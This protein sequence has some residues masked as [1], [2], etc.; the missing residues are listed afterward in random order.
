MEKIKEK[1]GIRHAVIWILVY[2]LLVNLGAMLSEGIGAEDA[3]TG[4]LLLLFSIYFWRYLQANNWLDYYG[5]RKTASADLMNSLYYAPL[6]LLVLFQFSN[7]IN[8]AIVP[9]KLLLIVLMMSGV[10]FLEELIFRGFLL[11]A[12]EEKSGRTRA[13]VIS[14]ITFGLGHIINL[15]RGYSYEEQVIQIL[16][17]AG[18]GIVLALLAFITQNIVPG[19]LFHILF[20]ISGSI[21]IEAAGSQA[22]YGL[23]LISILC[24][25]YSL[26]LFRM[27]KNP[28]RTYKNHHSLVSNGGR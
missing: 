12:I 8:S 19:I 1:N 6:V 2:L 25:A 13:V 7:G 22:F 9:G 10:G 28:K 23:L 21:T 20:N 15:F 3:A 14:G 11:K 16:A 4:V 24:A 27:I 26:Y 17:A 5:L 18:I